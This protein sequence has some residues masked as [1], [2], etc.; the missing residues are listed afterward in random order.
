MAVRDWTPALTGAKNVTI[1]TITVLRIKS[2]TSQQYVSSSNP[3]FKNPSRMLNRLASS[4][5]LPSSPYEERSRIAANFSLLAL[6]LKSAYKG[7]PIA[8]KIMPGNVAQK[9]THACY[10]SQH[11]Y[12]IS[13]KS[14]FQPSIAMQLTWSARAPTMVGQNK[15]RMIT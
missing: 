4:L 7:M 9:N 14:R 10:P 5:V 6:S 8:Q 2:I 11:F 13:L 15:K 3:A 12:S 1:I